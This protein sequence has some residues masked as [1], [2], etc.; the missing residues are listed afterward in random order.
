MCGICGFNFEDKLLLKKMC[1]SIIHR[2]PDEDG[3][4]LDKNISLG[5]R[6][7]SIIDIEKG[8]QPQ[9]NEDEDIWIVFNGE[10]YNYLD[11]K[12][13][14]ENKNHIFYTNSDTEV[15][16][17]SY[18]EYG[19]ECL[20]KLRGQFAFCIYDDKEKKFFIA[21]DHLGLKPLYYFYNGTNFIFGSEIKSILCHNIERKVNKDGLNSYLS[22][23]YTPAPLTLFQGIFKLPPACFLEFNLTNNQ[24][25]IQ[26]YWDLKFE[27]CFDKPTHVLG[28][29]LKN[30]LRESVKMRMMSDVPI[31]AF[32]SG[33]I[34][35]SSIVA[36]MSNLS[37]EPITTYS[38]GFNNNK[39]S[40][41]TEFSRYIANHFKTNHNEIIVN[42]DYYKLFPRLVYY[43]DDLIADPATLP[44]YTMSRLAKNK[45]T[46]A[47]TGDGADEVFG[48]YSIY[49]RI[50]ELTFKERIIPNIIT[51]L[52]ENYYKYIPSMSLK[53]IYSYLKMSKTKTDRLLRSLIYIPDEERKYALQ[54]NPKSIYNK[55]SQEFDE[56]KDL[57]NQ[58]IKWELLKQLPNHY[59]M[60]TDKM[61]MAASLET[62]IPFLDIRLVEWASKLPTELKVKGFTEK[63][64]LRLAMRDLLPSKILKRKKQGFG[65]PMYKWFRKGLKSVSSQLFDNL[66][67]RNE[68]FN[69]YYIKRIKEN[70][71][72]KNY[73]M[74]TWILIMF[75]IW[76]ETFIMN[77]EIK[78]INI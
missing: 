6:R 16:I 9:H 30:L 8:S 59:N 29:E 7:L 70:R 52:L 66:M 67:E 63:Y 17:H 31:G 35:S 72:K 50:N 58:V 19:Y 62:R 2:G 53:M 34:D 1:N 65:V 24:I 25:K 32:L 76:Y 55:L 46:V 40:D 48:G 49:Y 27:E 77:K 4:Y 14:L 28:N 71:F 38:I 61:S 12:S 44:V 42:S 23:R 37:K 15:I 22:L 33:G 74:R 68:F 18:E 47:L 11:L 51:C 56:K 13:N 75:E 78:P 54:Y 43:F 45:I 26:K 69:P 21:R 39:D 57:L 73:E 10:I 64:I 36:I 3:L 60:K 41:E 20:N 5:M